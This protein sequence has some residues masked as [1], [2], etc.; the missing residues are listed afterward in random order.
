MKS[1][2]IE[3][4]YLATGSYKKFIPGFFGSLEFFFPGY[5]KIITVIS[6]D[7]SCCKDVEVDDSVIEFNIRKVIQLPYPFPSYFKYNYV[8]EYC[9]R[10]AD[11]VFY[12]DAD[13]VFV[14]NEFFV[15]DDVLKMADENILLSFHPFYAYDE[16]DYYAPGLSSS[17]T[18][19]NPEYSTYIE[20][21]TYDYIIGSFFAGNT[22]NILK[23]CDK[24]INMMAEDLKKEGRRWYI[25]K[26]MDEAYLNS[27]SLHDNELSFKR[28][29]FVVLKTFE[30]YFACTICKQKDFSQVKEERIID[31][32]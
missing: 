12:F 23:L 7:L 5:S 13:T 27:I 26:Y 16:E 10:K 15:C 29:Q 30:D 19:R 18:E 8:R 1:K 20:Y 4:I 11:Y 2:T 31:S 22:E 17:N 9:S 32:L 3:I 25:P 28:M 14:N 24:I 21:D 6:D